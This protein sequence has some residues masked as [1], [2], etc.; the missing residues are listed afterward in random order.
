MRDTLTDGGNMI[1]Q[2][3][4]DSGS[5]LTGFQTRNTAV[6]INDQGLGK[7]L[8]ASNNDNEMI[9][10]L[11]K[12]RSKSSKPSLSQSELLIPVAISPSSPGMGVS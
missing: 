12:G 9:S 6:G 1:G 3:T 8:D 2:S 10:P 4:H 11:K 7:A 5:M